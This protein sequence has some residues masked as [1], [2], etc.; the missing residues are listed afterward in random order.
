MVLT[1][2]YQELGAD[3]FDQQRPEATSRQLV[4]LLEKLHW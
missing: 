2:S 1:K 3:Y 4:K